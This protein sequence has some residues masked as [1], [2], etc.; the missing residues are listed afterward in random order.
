MLSLEPHSQLLTPLPIQQPNPTIPSYQMP[1][2]P[3]PVP[4]SHLKHKR[5]VRTREAQTQVQRV[6]VQ[7]VEHS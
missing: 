2:F 6:T 7:A 3:V 1:I 5:K 4:D